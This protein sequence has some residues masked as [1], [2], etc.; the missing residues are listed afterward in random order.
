M[1]KRWMLIIAIAVLTVMT[2]CS[3]TKLGP[4]GRPY[5]VSKGTKATEAETLPPEAFDPW[6]MAFIY[7]MKDQEFQ[8]VTL[9]VQDMT[10]DYL[11][12]ML[13]EYGVLDEGTQI[14]SFEVVTEKDTSGS[15]VVSGPFG[16][17]GVV[18]DENGETEAPTVQNGILNLSQVPDWSAE[19]EKDMLACVGNTFMDNYG[20]DKLKLL[21]NGESYSGAGVTL[22]SD[23]YLEFESGYKNVSE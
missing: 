11:L 16:Q 21:V 15:G 20:L 19:E 2:A 4:D 14:L 13:I 6:E 5:K 18:S 9:D 7:R 17:M 8:R 10:E 1:K 3:P 12:E 22:G 23:D